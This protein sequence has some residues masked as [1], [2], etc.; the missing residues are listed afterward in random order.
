MGAQEALSPS[1][2]GLWN[3]AITFL[4]KG[5]T[6]VDVVSASRE[7]V[8]GV[9]YNLLVNAQNENATYTLCAIEVLE[10]PWILNEWGDKLR[11]LQYTNCTSENSKE[12]FNDAEYD[13]KSNSN[14]FNFNPLFS[15]K[16][17]DITD[18][19]LKALE[20]QI[21]K[22]KV[23]STTKKPQTLNEDAFLAE[24]EA[25][26]WQPK[27]KSKPTT[28]KK[29]IILFEPSSLFNEND[30]MKILQEESIKKS[31]AKTIQEKKVANGVDN[32]PKSLVHQIVQTEQKAETISSNT[33]PNPATEELSTSQFSE[34]VQVAI[35][36]L[37]IYNNNDAFEMDPAIVADTVHSIDELQ[38]TTVRFNNEFETVPEFSTET[39]PKSS[40]EIFLP[41]L[42]TDLS[43]IDQST[44]LNSQMLKSTTEYTV[45]EYSTPKSIKFFEFG[46]SPDNVFD[47]NNF[48]KTLDDL[49]KNLVNELIVTT[50]GTEY[51]KNMATNDDTKTLFRFYEFNPIP[52]KES[53]VKQTQ[54][55]MD[56][57]I[58]LLFTEL[59]NVEQEFSKG[60]FDLIYLEIN[61]KENPIYI[62]QNIKSSRPHA[63]KRKHS[64]ESRSSKSSESKE[65]SVDNFK[66]I[67]LTGHK[68]D[69]NEASEVG[70][71]NFERRKSSSSS[72]ESIEKSMQNNEK[73]AKNTME[74]DKIFVI[75]FLNRSIDLDDLE[76]VASEILQPKQYFSDVNVLYVLKIKSNS[77][78]ECIRGNSSSVD[79]NAEKKAGCPNLMVDTTKI[80]NIQVMHIYVILPD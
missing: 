25:Q 74:F 44:S 80:C 77:F 78:T 65:N 26:I 71:E 68:A 52:E 14:N 37:F 40:S 30:L 61:V 22:P 2:V 75:N 13:A 6:L 72:S 16:Y 79:M 18:E 59:V 31:D 7:V 8:A 23:K 34:S 62:D 38:S 50:N 35:D 10:K 69:S 15:N 12:K 43:R 33:T 53:E 64:R 55:T 20:D 42:T 51:N 66:R 45:N 73:P 54:L 36:E 32:W 5:Y 9:R 39:I 21:I 3:M 56:D 11:T 1:L 17:N 41:Q 46:P 57:A 28:T 76:R 67:K 19:M 49:V 48:E 4:P 70:Q 24:L 63:S 27:V 58:G 60:I 47:D 29:P